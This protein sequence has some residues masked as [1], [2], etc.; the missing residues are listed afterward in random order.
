[1]KNL[2]TLLCALLL[3]GSFTMVVGC[4]GDQDVDEK[5]KVEQKDDDKKMDKDKDKKMDDDKKMEKKS[6][7]Y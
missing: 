6:R 2:M 4:A 7:R 3:C 5:D 1:M